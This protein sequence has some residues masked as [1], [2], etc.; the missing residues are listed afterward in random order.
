MEFSNTH[1]YMWY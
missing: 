1:K